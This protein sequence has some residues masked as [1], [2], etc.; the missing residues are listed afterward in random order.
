MGVEGL[1]VKNR[2]HVF[3]GETPQELASLTIEIL[4]NRE[5]AELAV[6]NA[7]DLIAKEYNWQKIATKLDSIY[8]SFN[9][10]R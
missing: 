6:R 7:R 4:A 9:N 8:E 10:Y 3:I 5:I 2:E 1:D